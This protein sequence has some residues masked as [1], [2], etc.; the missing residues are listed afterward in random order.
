MTVEELVMRLRNEC[1][2][3]NKEWDHDGADQ[4]LIEFIGS[5]EVKDFYKKAGFWYA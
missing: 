1:Q 5:P 3:G 4:L 2:T